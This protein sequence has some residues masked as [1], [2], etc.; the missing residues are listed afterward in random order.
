MDLCNLC[1]VKLFR[2]SR[3]LEYGRLNGHVAS[4]ESMFFKKEV[5]KGYLRRGG[6][7]LRKVD[8]IPEGILRYVLCTVEVLLKKS[9]RVF[10]KKFCKEKILS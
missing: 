5:L 8:F 6:A 7:D 2:S 9:R 3:V 10:Y 4:I 1:R